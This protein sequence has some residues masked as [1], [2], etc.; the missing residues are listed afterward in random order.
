MKKF[1]WK[2]YIYKVVVIILIVFFVVGVGFGAANILAIEG[3]R[4]IYEPEEPLQEFPDTNEKVIEYVNSVITKAIETKPMTELSESYS[5]DNDSINNSA[6]D[7]K[8]NACMKKISDNLDSKVEDLFENQAADYSENAEFL[9]TLNIK[10]ADV[11]KIELNYE[12]YK[13]SMCTSSV[14]VEDYGEECPECGN[15]GTLDLRYSDDYEITIHIKPDS[16]TFRTCSM[17]E[18]EGL[19]KIIADSGD[20]FYTLTGFDKKDTEAFIYVKVNRLTDKISTLRLE[21]KSTVTADLKLENSYKDIGNVELSYDAEDRYNYSFTWPGVSLN[22]HEMIVELGSSEVLKATLT[23]DNPIDYDVKWSSSNEDILTVDDEGYLKTHKKFGDAV[24]TA[25]FTFKDVTYEDSCLVHVGVPAEG[26][27]LSKGKLKLNVGDEYTLV[28]KFDPKD[29]TNT[30]CYWNTNDDSIAKIDQNGKV[31]AT[32]KGN[33]TVYVITDDGNY[34][35]SC[36]VEV[37]N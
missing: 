5:I 13:C 9:S 1:D 25:K 23:C 31:T 32:G 4:E 16:E 6:N 36:E 14:S 30:I 37:N 15:Q 35:S 29:T 19:E 18:T 34:Y 11:D 3:T 17:P 8:I 33:T 22:K 2:K 26:V 7:D 10:P 24:I 28:A 20:S 27:D 21:T 12:Y